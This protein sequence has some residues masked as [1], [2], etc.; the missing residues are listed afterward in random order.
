VSKYFIINPNN[1]ANDDSLSFKTYKSTIRE[2]LIVHLY[3]YLYK[4]FILMDIKTLEVNNSA[5]KD[6]AIN[7]Y[8][9]NQ[10]SESRPISHINVVHRINNIIN[11]RLQNMIDILKIKNGEAALNI[12]GDRMLSLTF[13]YKEL[14]KD[15]YD[16]FMQDQ[17]E[18]FVAN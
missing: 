8:E 9:I 4:Y 12:S 5:E 14:N 3:V 18:T 1:S 15:V 10:V 17:V 11:S 16:L 13:Q 6:K 2:T 7:T